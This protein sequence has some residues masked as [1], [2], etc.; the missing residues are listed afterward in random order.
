MKVKRSKNWCDIAMFYCSKGRRTFV[1]FN[2][3]NR[4]CVSV[5]HRNSYSIQRMLLCIYS[6]FA[7]LFFFRLISCLPLSWL[8][9]KL[10]FVIVVLCN[11]ISEKS[12]HQRKA[13]EFRLSALGVDVPE[14]TQIVVHGHGLCSVVKFGAQF[15]NH[16]FCYRRISC[17]HAPTFLPLEKFVVELVVFVKLLQIL[18]QFTRR[19]F[20]RVDVGVWWSKLGVIHSANHNWHD[21]T[22]QDFEKLFRHVISTQGILKRQVKL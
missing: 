6:S 7:P 14:W 13:F 19:V 2:Y 18:S 21:S 3:T 16:S 12:K 9:V 1:I 17:R 5:P 8:V 11:S 20:A 4:W 15:T 10:F 22:L